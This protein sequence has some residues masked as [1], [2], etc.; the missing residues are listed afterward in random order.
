MECI[1]LLVSDMISNRRSPV[2]HVFPMAIPVTIPAAV[3]ASFEST[4]TQK[5]VRRERRNAHLSAFAT[6][7]S[8]QRKIQNRGKKNESPAR[9]SV[10]MVL[11]TAAF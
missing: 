10:R 3:G 2:L 5:R 1:Y 8:D 6:E 9:V 11:E 7:F 4:A